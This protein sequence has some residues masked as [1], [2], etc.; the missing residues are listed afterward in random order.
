MAGHGERPTREARVIDAIDVQ[1][2]DLHDID[3]Q[4]TYAK[5]PRSPHRF[6]RGTD[7]Q[8]WADIADDWRIDLY[9]GAPT[10]RASICAGLPIWSPPT[11]PGW[12]IPSATSAKPSND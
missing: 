12:Q 4:R 7:H 9:D 2:R 11:R 10:T 5:M 3:R 8:F 1:N 6:F